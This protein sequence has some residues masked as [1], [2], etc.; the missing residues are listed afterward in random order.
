LRSF[1]SAY[2]EI[3]LISSQL[4]KLNSFF[5]SDTSISEEEVLAVAG[6]PES[7]PSPVFALAF[8][9]VVFAGVAVLQFSL[10]FHN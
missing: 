6:A 4:G 3:S 7:L 8:A 2:D 1:Q 5:L 10:G 9:F